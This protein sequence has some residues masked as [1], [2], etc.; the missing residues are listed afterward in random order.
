[1]LTVFNFFSTYRFD[2]DWV[3][4]FEDVVEGVED[5]ANITLN[6]T[7][8]TIIKNRVTSDTIIRVV[9]FDFLSKIFLNFV[10]FSTGPKRDW[11]VFKFFNSNAAAMSLTL[12]AV[13]IL[14]D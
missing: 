6:T 4:L 2:E 10:F 7:I 3:W 5:E 13:F 11:F 9:W 8:V 12:F 14:W 1:M